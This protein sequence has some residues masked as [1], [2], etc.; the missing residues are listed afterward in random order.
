MNTQKNFLG[1][2]IY[3]FKIGRFCPLSPFE[4]IQSDC[5]F[6]AP[7]A[8]QPET[9]SPNQTKPAAAMIS[10]TSSSLPMAMICTPSH[11]FSS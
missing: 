9:G 3:I 5:F 8:D 7:P 11:I 6:N 2:I 4:M 1:K 10:G